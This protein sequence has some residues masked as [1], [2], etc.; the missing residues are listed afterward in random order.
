MTTRPVG[1]R[2]P[3]GV[4][5]CWPWAPGFWRLVQSCIGSVVGS[6]GSGLRHLRETSGCAVD[7]PREEDAYG[8]RHVK[9]KR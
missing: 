3:R 8:N 6:N 9:L 2:L 1:A 5:L 7:V 4:P